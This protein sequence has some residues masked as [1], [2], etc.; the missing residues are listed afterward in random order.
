VIRCETAAELAKLAANTLFDFF[1]GYNIL[2]FKSPRDPLSVAEYHRIMA[3]AHLYIADH[4]PASTTDVIICV[5]CSA[6]PVKVLYQVPDEVVFRRIGGGHYES[7]DLACIDREKI[8]ALSQ[9]LSEVKDSPEGAN[10]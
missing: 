6:K 8:E 9:K 5:A 7:D 3:R 2:E 4:P 1:R 10:S